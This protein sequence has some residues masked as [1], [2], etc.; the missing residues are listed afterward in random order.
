MQDEAV[1]SGALDPT[2]SITTPRGTSDAVTRTGFSIRVQEKVTAT[3][4]T[5]RAG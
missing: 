4:G 1:V 5:V 3:S 2:G